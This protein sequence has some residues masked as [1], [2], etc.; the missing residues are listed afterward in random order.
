M[1]PLTRQ[2]IWSQG[3]GSLA[4]ERHLQDP[5]RQQGALR[6]SDQEVLGKQRPQK[7]RSHRTANRDRQS[8]DCRTT[9]GTMAWHTARYPTRLNSLTCRYCARARR[10]RAFGESQTIRYRVSSRANP[11]ISIPFR[12]RNFLSRALSQRHQAPRSMRRGPVS[13]ER[14]APTN[15]HNPSRHRSGLAAG[16]AARSSICRNSAALVIP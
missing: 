13:G 7:Y 6:L 16:S 1:L 9:Q 2:G 14:S 5:K 11:L 8:P 10:K 12:P 3:S 15:D 4:V